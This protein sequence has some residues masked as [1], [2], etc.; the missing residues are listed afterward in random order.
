MKGRDLGARR[1]DTKL[2]LSL[3][4]VQDVQCRPTTQSCAMGQ[5]LAWCEFES[6]GIYESRRVSGRRRARTLAARRRVRF[7][8]SP[9]YAQCIVADVV[10]E[11]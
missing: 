2:I 3:V 4:L 6:P 5:S 10:S 9:G 7:G 11:S 1:Q 8:D